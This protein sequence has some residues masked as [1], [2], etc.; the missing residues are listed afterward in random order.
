MKP[1]PRAGFD[2]RGVET[3]TVK[4]VRHRQPKGSVNGLAP[5]TH[6][7]TPRLYDHVTERASARLL[8][9]ARTLTEADIR[10]TGLGLPRRAGTAL[11]LRNQ[12]S[13]SAPPELDGVIFGEPAS[14]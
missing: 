2:E 7:A 5:P 6:R 14:L 10:L 11:T 4:L 13:G 12:I 9:R 1:C 8:S 3:G